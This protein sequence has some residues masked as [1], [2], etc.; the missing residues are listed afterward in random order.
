VLSRPNRAAAALLAKMPLVPAASASVCL[1]KNKS[2]QPEL[3]R[4]HN[5][6]RRAM[7]TLVCAFALLTAAAAA[8]QPVVD[9]AALR[10]DPWP[11]RNATITVKDIFTARKTPVPTAM[12]E[13]GYSARDYLHFTAGRSGMPCYVRKS[14]PVAALLPSLQPGDQVTIVGRVVQP[15]ITVKRKGWNQERIKLER[16]ILVVTSL[17]KGWGPPP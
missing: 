12:A 11:Y 5:P 2:S 8:A 4:Q 6:G 9:P 13:A 7:K 3:G 16:F 15:K 17:E 10:S 1:L 14:S